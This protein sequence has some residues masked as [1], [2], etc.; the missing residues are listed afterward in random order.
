M[1][2]SAVILARALAFVESFDLAPRGGVFWADLVRELVARY[3][4]QKFPVKI[5]DFD[6][7]KGV[8]FLSGKIG[9]VV[10]EK[11]V[12]YNTA[13][14]V[15][16]R[17]STTTSEQVLR[18]ALEWA[19]K[20][21]KLDYKPENIK[22]VANISQLTFHSDISLDML[23]PA[24]KRLSDSVSAAVS[25]VH[26]EKFE[27]QTSQ[28]AITHDPLKR[29]YT[30]AGFTIVPRAETPYSEHKYFSE[31]PLPTDLHIKLLEQFERDLLGKREA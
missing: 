10:I 2:L 20:Q 29:K 12:I 26:G 19:K 18:E 9:D 28:I 16:T 8:E 17:V 14:L 15:D 23:H 7:N 5:E 22:R 11:L 30:I 13:I 31:A 21:F 1:Q 3:Q 4:F 24:L 25:E 27:Y 6:E